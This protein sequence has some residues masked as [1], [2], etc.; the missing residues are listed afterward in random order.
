MH[1]KSLCTFMIVLAGI[2]STQQAHSAD[3]HAGHSHDITGLELGIT[4]GFVHLEGEDE[5]APGLHVHLNKRL[6]HEGPL[7]R[8]AL[9]VGGE[10]ILADHE[11]YALMAPL[12]FYPWRG[13]MLSIAPGIEWAE[14]DG[15]TESEYTTHIELGYG[16]EMGKYDIG[17]VIEFAQTA[18]EEHYMLGVHFGI[19]L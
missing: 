15:A 14:H 16:F 8:V 1:T 11:H 10:I 5:D 13:L 2:V 4:A 9:G 7:S 17:P 12:T 18:D 3:A 19:H 6:S